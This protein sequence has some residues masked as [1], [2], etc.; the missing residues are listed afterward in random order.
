MMT[1]DTEYYVPYI[2]VNGQRYI[3]ERL[4]EE[5]WTHWKILEDQ[6]RR[7]QGEIRRLEHEQSLSVARTRTKFPRERLRPEIR[8]ANDHSDVADM[9]KCQVIPEEAV[10]RA[11]QA[12]KDDPDCRQ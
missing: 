12:Y 8:P 1:T 9:K 3:W 2:V 6:K 5:E 10:E 7:L 11:R 4:D